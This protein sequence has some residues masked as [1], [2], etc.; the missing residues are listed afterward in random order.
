MRERG[1]RERETGRG[2]GGSEMRGTD[3]DGKRQ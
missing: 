3:R 1:E 2:E